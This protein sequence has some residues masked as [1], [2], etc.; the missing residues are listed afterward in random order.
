MK[1]AWIEKATEHLIKLQD[2]ID[3]DDKQMFLELMKKRCGN[4]DIIGS[5]SVAVAVGYANV[6][7]SLNPLK[8]VNSI[9]TTTT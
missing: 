6:Y 2:A 4:N 3:S 7:E 1:E 8:R 9:L 5:D